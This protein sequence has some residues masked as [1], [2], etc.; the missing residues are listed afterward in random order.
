MSS[1]VFISILTI[2][3]LIQFGKFTIIIV[4]ALKRR[5][6]ADRRYFIDFPGSVVTFGGCCFLDIASIVTIITTMFNQNV[7][8]YLI[9]MVFSITGMFTLAISLLLRIS[10]SHWVFIPKV[11][12]NTWKTRASFQSIRSPRTKTMEQPFS[13]YSNYKKPQ[14]YGMVLVSSSFA[15]TIAVL[16]SFL[17]WIEID[18]KIRIEEITSPIEFDTKIDSYA[19]TKDHFCT[20]DNSFLFFISYFAF[21]TL[22]LLLATFSAFKNK[23]NKYQSKFLHQATALRVMAPISMTIFIA[24]VLILVVFSSSSSSVTLRLFI[25]LSNCVMS[26]VIFSIM[27]IQFTLSH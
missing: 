22:I 10:L 18:G 27:A 23:T 8:L 2:F 16:V 3:G 17:I 26:L 14:H 24:F 9:W 19:D 13:N 1:A 20:A 5:N 15:I 21:F 7:H 4:L 11:S 12:S 6:V 25:S